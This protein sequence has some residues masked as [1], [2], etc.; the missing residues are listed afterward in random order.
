M[1]HQQWSGVDCWRSVRDSVR[2]VARPPNRADPP[3]PN[4]LSRTCFCERSFESSFTSLPP[5][6][7]S[8]P[9]PIPSRTC[10]VS[11][12]TSRP[13]NVRPSLTYLNVESIPTMTWL[14]LF[15]LVFHSTSLPTSVYKHLL[16]WV[17]LFTDSP[18]SRLSLSSLGTE[19]TSLWRFFYFESESSED[20]VFTWS[21]LVKPP[22][23]LF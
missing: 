9:P 19:S 16:L 7:S 3:Q 23:K 6:N 20:T 17:S 2:C 10:R 8:P 5:R 18:L 13:E 14:I 15:I 1:S 4:L 21:S 12:C 22:K 11:A